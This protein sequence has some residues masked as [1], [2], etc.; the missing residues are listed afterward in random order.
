MPTIIGVVGPHDLVTSVADLCDQTSGV[1]IQRFAYDHETEASR[2][3]DVHADEVD[4]WLFTGVIPYTV[5]AEHLTR[6]AAYIDYTGTSLLHAVI[7]L[8]IDGHDISRLSIDTLATSDVLDALAESELATSGVSSLPFRAGLTSDAL[9]E[10]HRQRAAE[11]AVAITCVSSVYETLRDEITILRLVPSWDSIRTTLRQLL[12]LTSNQTSEDAHVVLGIVKAQP[13]TEELDKDLARE[14]AGIAGVVCPLEEGSR[15][16]I[17]TR[18][19]LADATNQ[20]TS[21]PILRRLA[22]DGRRILIGFGFGRGAAEAER[23]ARRALAR[24]ASHGQVAAVASFRN[25][26]DI[27]L[28]VDHGIGTGKTAA[29]APGIGVITARVGLSASTVRRLRDAASGT[30]PVTTRDIASALGIEQRTARRMMQ[31]LELAGYAERVG[32]NASGASGRPLT[33]YRLTF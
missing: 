22:T 1:D 4:A 16:V 21:A 28:D 30:D 9:M 2:I 25:D 7:R 13:W 8:V 15:L 32:R 27:V 12:L 33:L 3:V 29:E 14:A 6:P 20:F 19:P 10:F 18:G 23:L 31:R 5:A 17:T 26:I 11:G 24:A